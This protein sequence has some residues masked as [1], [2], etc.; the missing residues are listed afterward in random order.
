MQI[1]QSIREKGAAIIIIVIAISLIGFILMDAK[2]GSGGGIFGGSNDKIG[3]VNGQNIS[4][5]EF[6]K[7]EKQMQ[8]IEAGKSGQQPSGARIDQIRDQLWNQIVAEN[9]FYKEAE[10]LGINITSTETKALLLSNDQTNP[11]MQERSLI[12]AD[13]KLDMTKALEAYN[14][15]KKAKG[16]QRE[17]IDASI[18]E[19]LRLS[20]AVAKYSGLISA[21]AYYPGWMKERDAT[22]GK[23]FANISYVAIP[24]TEISDSTVTVSDAD[25]TGYVAKHKDLFKQEAGRTISYVT[26][27]QLPTAVDSARVKKSVE[28]LKVTFAADTN[29][30]SFVGRNT[31]TIDFVDDFLPKAKIN[32]IFTD[33]II[34]EQIG[35]VV[36]PYVDGK[37]YVIA[38]VTGTKMMP[39]S[40]KAKHILIGTNDPQTG[41]S[42][43]ED[44]TAKKLA[45][46]IL[47]MV[48][49]G[50]D[51]AAL[52][53]QYSTDQGSK[54]K[55]GDLGSFGYGQMVPEFNE[56][57]F[58]KTAGTRGV[59]KTQ[60][61]YH[62]I[63][64]VSQTAMKPAYK[65][66]FIGKE[67]NASD[68]TV[69][70]ASLASTK[71]AA[72]K[73]A[74]SLETYLKT[75]GKSIIVNPAI[76]KEN[77]FAIGNMQQARSLIKWA[78]G[79]KKG[80][81][82]EPFSI[83]EDFVVATVNNIYAEGTQDATLA[84]KGSEAVIRNQKKAAIIVAKIGVASTLENAATAY[85]KTIMTAGADSSI[86]MAAQI[87][88]GLGVEYKIIGAAFNKENL[89]KAS[90]PIEGT[91]GVYVIKT[92]S[93]QNKPDPSSEAQLQQKD[94]GLQKIRQQSANWF[95]ALKKQSDIIDKR[96]SVY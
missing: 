58:S 93:I 17:M 30:K 19:P 50:S 61:G 83:G 2:P 92:N 76:I 9:I 79:A 38:K 32:S 43:M 72:Q 28:E 75:I 65:I 35:T 81:V 70:E 86:T 25:I 71:A 96:S 46:S 12:G 49:N 57:A 37:N 7:R 85:S 16:D 8:D 40:V 15:I 80:Q 41:K 5:Q 36:G 47:N 34:K 53:K 67:I 20:N 44:A 77:D 42:I 91:S 62:V 11:L 18:L 63:E 52:A 78:F 59:V 66:A 33:T 56:F 95:E 45:D 94:V 88:N 89:A 24:Y 90:A 60:F 21:A 39:D 69:G 23:T 64:V 55:G 87:I 84:R 10:K 73:D 68:A 74:A 14:N 3:K 22:E 29:S 13:G 51:F 26:F 48:N 31:S 82:S 6:I 4:R 54:E 1:I 27:S